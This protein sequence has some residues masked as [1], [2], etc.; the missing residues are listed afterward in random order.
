MRPSHP[1]YAVNLIIQSQIKKIIYRKN[2]LIQ[3]HKKPESQYPQGFDRKNPG[4]NL[5]A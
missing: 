1:V 5:I 3:T 2:P 4:A